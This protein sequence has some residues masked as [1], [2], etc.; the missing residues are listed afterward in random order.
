MRE[1]FEVG[2]QKHQPFDEFQID[3]LMKLKHHQ[4][5]FFQDLVLTKISSGGLF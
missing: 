1:N 4:L 5:G 2:Q 3:R